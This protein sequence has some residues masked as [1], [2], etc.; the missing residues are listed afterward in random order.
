MKQVKFYINEEHYEKLRKLAEE[1]GLSVPAYVK[2]LVLKAL[3][4]LEPGIEETVKYLEER[5]EQLG[6]EVGR[7]GID[8]ARVIKRVERLE[9]EIFSR[10]Q[11]AT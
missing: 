1:Q 7:I 10:H 3:G 4:E 9:R 2:N 8:L 6:K 11:R 5:T